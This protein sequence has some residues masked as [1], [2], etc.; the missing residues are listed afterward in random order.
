M[1]NSQDKH[2]QDSGIDSESSYPEDSDLQSVHGG[3]LISSARSLISDV[4][5]DMRSFHSE[6]EIPHTE[7]YSDNSAEALNDLVRE[8][9]AMLANK[10]AFNDGFNLGR[11]VGNEEGRSAGSKKAWAK[12]I[13]GAVLGGL[14]GAGVAEGI[15]DIGDDS[16]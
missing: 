3:S 10:A 1:E 12:G 2:K 11:K 16:K 14:G 15:R 8:K 13:I 6:S 9:Q 5:K 4:F 7:I